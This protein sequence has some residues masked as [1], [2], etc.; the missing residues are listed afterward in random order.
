MRC[1]FKHR[2]TRIR[3]ISFS[4]RKNQSL[5]TRD[6]QSRQSLIQQEFTQRWCLAVQVLHGVRSTT[7]HAGSHELPEWMRRRN[8]LQHTLGFMLIRFAAHQDMHSDLQL[9][10]S[11]GS[12]QIGP[13]DLDHQSNLLPLIDGV[14]GVSGSLNLFLKHASVQLAAHIPERSLDARAWQAN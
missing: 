14:L 6:S 7:G 2:S 12:P 11:R 13:H 1:A 5:G 3:L 10:A 4:D 9:D 8:I